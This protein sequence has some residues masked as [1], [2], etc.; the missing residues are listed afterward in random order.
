LYLEQNVYKGQQP[1]KVKGQGL[2]G[3]NE[4]REASVTEAPT[5]EKDE[6]II[7]IFNKR[8]TAIYA[9]SEKG[10][11]TVYEWDTLEVQESFLTIRARVKEI[12]FSRDEKLLNVNTSKGGLRIYDNETFE[13]LREFQDVVNRVQW[14]RSCFSGSGEYVVGGAAIKDKQHI[15]V[16]ERNFGQLVKILEGPNQALSSLTY[17]PLQPLLAAVGSSGLIFVW[18]KNY[19]ENWSAFATDFVE[20]EDNEEYIEREDEFDVDPLAKKETV[21]EEEEE[22]DIVTPSTAKVFSDDDDDE[23]VR[24]S[25]DR[26]DTTRIKTILHSTETA[27]HCPETTLNVIIAIGAPPDDSQNYVAGP[28]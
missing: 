20:L 14:K 12:V 15:Y 8:G 7:A 4:E 5:V 26:D 1:K 24:L 21:E 16:W 19:Q 25:Q 2:G 11:L 13:F 9:G 23:L 10:Y 3:E 18:H 17:H 27:T 28:R 6:N 22:L